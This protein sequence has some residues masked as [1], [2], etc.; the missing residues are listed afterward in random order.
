[1]YLN[2]L[3]SAST[4][5][6]P[7]QGREGRAASRAVL[8]FTYPCKSRTRVSFFWRKRT[9]RIVVSEYSNWDNCCNRSARR[10]EMLLAHPDESQ[11]EARPLSWPSG[12]I[13]WK[14]FGTVASAPF[15]QVQS[16]VGR[17]QEAGRRL[18][19]RSVPGGE[20]DADGDR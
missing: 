15:C 9:L 6:I 5:G 7:R 11:A 8:Q 18:L 17:S 16:A 4:A 1:M 12:G 2:G 10:I 19:N 20:T 13:H 3:W 14:E